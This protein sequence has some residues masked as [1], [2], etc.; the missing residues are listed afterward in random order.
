MTERQKNPM[1]RSRKPGD[2]YIETLDPRIGWRW[3]ILKT[4]QQDG[5]KPYAR[6]FCNVH[7]FATEM[8]DV[9]VSEI[10]R[11]ILG[12]DEDVFS[13]EEEARRALFGGPA[14]PKPKPSEGFDADAQAYLRSIGLA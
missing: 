7:G 6:A 10:G 2:A 5:S 14:K 12:Y 11:V 9:Y 8:G 13:S 3:E 1:G 4:Y